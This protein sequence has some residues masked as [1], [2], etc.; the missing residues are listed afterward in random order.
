MDLAAGDV[1]I[2]PVD[3]AHTRERPRQMRDGE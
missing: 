2:D 1:Q 3:R